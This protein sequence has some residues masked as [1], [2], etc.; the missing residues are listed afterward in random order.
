MLLLAGLGACA[1]LLAAI[2]IYGVTAYAVT[3]RTAEFGI[4]LALGA[5]TGGV[6]HMVMR[7][8]LVLVGA[9]TAIGLGLSLVSTRFLNRLLFGVSALDPVTFAGAALVLIAVAMAASYIPA[10]RVTQVD[11]MTALRAD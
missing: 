3:Q 9:G 2:G 5:Q 7:Q 1:M 4:R 6:I 10:R 11:P 8:N